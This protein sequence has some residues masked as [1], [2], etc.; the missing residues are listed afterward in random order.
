VKLLQRL[1]NSVDGIEGPFILLI[2]GLT[3]IFVAAWMDTAE[4][5]ALRKEYIDACQDIGGRP[6]FNGKH[7]ECWKK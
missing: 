6:Y 4:R 5:N 2:A 7:M 3:A 1:R